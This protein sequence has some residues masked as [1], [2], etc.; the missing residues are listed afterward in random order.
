LLQDLEEHGAEREE[1]QIGPAE[2]Q[3]RPPDF[4]TMGKISQPDL[5]PASPKGK[6]DSKGDLSGSSFGDGLNPGNPNPLEAPGMGDLESGH[7]FF[8]Y[9]CGKEGHHTRKCAKNLWCDI[10]RKETHVTARCVWPKHSKPIMPIVDMAADG[11]G[12]YAS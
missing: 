5:T 9:N 6:G 7:R 8:C 1:Y 12:F 11:L 3:G 10:C 2:S 4:A